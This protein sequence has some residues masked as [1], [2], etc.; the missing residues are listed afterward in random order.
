MIFNELAIVESTEEIA[1]NT[2]QTF[3]KSPKIAASIKPGQFINILPSEYWDKM[4]R[5]PMSV[6]SQKDEVISIIYKVVGEGTELMQNWS[7]GDSVDLIGPLGNF[8]DGYADKLSI[9]IGGGV[10]IAPI[11]NL[12]NHLDELGEEKVLIMG[13][14][15]SS[16]HFIDHNPENGV[17]M[18]TDDGSLGI[19]GNVLEPLKIAL[20]N[21]DIQNVKVFTC[22]PPAMMEA[23]RQYSISEGIECDL[24]LETLMACGFGICQGCTLEFEKKQKTTEHSYRNRFGL[25]CMDGPIFE[26]KEIKSCHL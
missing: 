21:I 5:R 23:V 11:L 22:G 1:S 15:N 2:F 16:E 19:H 10:G 26:S 8:W 3:L 14:R 6:A 17:Y 18:T 24:A 20:E 12:H 25:V 4:M 13:A 9:L 7:V